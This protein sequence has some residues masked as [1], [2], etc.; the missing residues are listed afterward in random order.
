MSAARELFL[1][2]PFLTF[3]DQVAYEK[4]CQ[5]AELWRGD[6]QHFSAGV[7]MLSAVHAAWGHLERMLEAQRAALKDFEQVI[8][9]QALDSPPSLAALYKLGQSLNHAS[10]LFDLGRQTTRIRIREL[11]SELAQRLLKY[12]GNSDHADN[13][14]VRGFVIATDLD[15]AWTSRFP[16]YEVPLGAEQLGQELLLSIPSA[17]NL[18]VSDRDWRGGVRDCE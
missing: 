15:G 9:E 16:T 18:F 13:Y 1:E 4:L 8:S 17:F 5:A 2:R 6:G 11:N 14:L 12:F 7:A 3:G 10:R